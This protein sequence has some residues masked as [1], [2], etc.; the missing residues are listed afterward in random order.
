M[1]LLTKPVVLGGSGSQMCIRE[2]LILV[3]IFI[4][5]KNGT[6]LIQF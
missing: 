6:Y 2:V 1:Y 4:S 5:Q 3:P